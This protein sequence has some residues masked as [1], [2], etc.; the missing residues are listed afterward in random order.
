LQ[1]EDTLTHRS[2]TKTMMRDAAIPA[3]AA[4]AAAATSNQQCTKDS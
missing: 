2:M 4:A 3:A 1:S